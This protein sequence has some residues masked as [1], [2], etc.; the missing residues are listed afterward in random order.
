MI[1]DELGLPKENG[2]SD[3][4]DSARLAG[5]MASIGMKVQLSRYIKYLNH[6]NAVGVRHPSEQPARNYK[7]FT[8]DQLLCLVAGLY[9]NKEYSTVDDLRTTIKLN[10]YRCQNTEYDYPGTTKS[11]PN[12]PDLLMPSHI[13]H[14]RMCAGLNPTIL[15][16]IW[17][18]AEIIYNAFV[19]PLAEPNQLICM[20]LVSGVDDLR[21]WTRLNKKWR[22]ALS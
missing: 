22:E 12:G 9:F 14:L 21:L 7:N 16:K 2:A 5:L 3:K 17:L 10:N 1:F 15:G 19:T 4:M 6:L 20:L 13:S 8:R 18:R 11:F